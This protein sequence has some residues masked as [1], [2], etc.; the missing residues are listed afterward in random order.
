MKNLKLLCDLLLDRIDKNKLNNLNELSTLNHDLNILNSKASI[1]FVHY[2]IELLDNIITKDTE[3]ILKNN[4]INKMTDYIPKA[5]KEFIDMNLINKLFENM[6]S[7]KIY[8]EKNL[9]FEFLN[10]APPEKINVVIIGIKPYINNYSS[11]LA[12]SLNNDS[13]DSTEELI[14]IRNEI[15]NSYRHVN[16]IN[17][18]KPWAEQGVLLI[19]R[20]L[21]RSKIDNNKYLNSDWD[22]IPLELIKNHSKK[23]KNIIYLL[24]G[25]D[26]YIFENVIDKNNN[27]V[28]KR[29]SYPLNQSCSSGTNPFKYSECF[30]VINEHLVLNN[31]SMIK[32]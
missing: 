8:P 10:Y 1:E 6:T 27:H 28:I 22:R 13:I 2:L 11:G 30:K 24:F 16:I 15:M 31:K 17:N 32:W 23:F 7:E 26:N 19:N 20:H 3:N 9:I 14:N 12:F 18:L 5:W 21:I 4:K 25:A 29:L